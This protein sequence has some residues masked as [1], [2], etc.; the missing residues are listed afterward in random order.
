[1]SFF[2]QIYPDSLKYLIDFLD[3][4]YMVIDGV[5]HIDSKDIIGDAQEWMDIVKN[6]KLAVIISHQHIIPSHEKNIGNFNVGPLGSGTNMS[7]H[8]KIKSSTN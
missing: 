4:D 8:V 7:A 3:A 1:M 2:L 5:T 6:R